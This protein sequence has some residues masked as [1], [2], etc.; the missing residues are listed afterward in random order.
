MDK[1]Y[2]VLY[3]PFSEIVLPK[4]SEKELKE[5]KKLKKLGIKS[6]YELLTYF[7]RGY[8][9]RTNIKAI[10]ELSENE[11]V[12]L[13]ATVLKIDS[14]ATFSNKKIVKARVADKTGVLEL[15]WF[16]APYVAKSL[17]LGSEYYFIGTAKRGYGW[18]MT[19]PEY[20]LLTSQKFMSEGE[21]LPIYSTTKDID[22]NVLRKFIKKFYIEYSDFFMENIPEELIRK[23]KIMDRKKTLYNIHF[24]KNERVL[25]EAKRRLAIEELLILEMGILS[26]RYSTD[27]KNH[28]LYQMEDKKDFVKIFLEG[29]K[30]ELTKA[31]K[32]V[33]TEVYKELSSGKIVNRLIQGDVGSG[34][35]I[36][37]MVLL[38]YMVENGYQGVIMAPTEILATQ[39][40]INNSQEFEKLGIKMELL[41]GSL[42]KKKKLEML[43]RIKSGK[44]DVV[45][46]THAVIQE[47][48]EFKK[49][50]LIVI[51]EQHRF[52]VEQRKAIRDKGVLANVIVMSA[53]PIPRSLALSIYGD[54]DVS[55][56]DELP[57]GR[58]AIKT[59]HISDHIDIEKMYGFI[60]KKLKET[61]QAYFIAPLIDESEKSNLKSVYELH[62]EVLKYLPD[63]RIG[64][65]HGKMKTQEKDEVMHRFKNHELDIIISTTVIEVG[66]NVTNASIMTI[67]DA[68]RFGLSSL[69]QLRGRVGRGE[70]QSYC[71][72]ISKSENET[73]VARMKIMEASNDGFYIAEEDLKL[74][75]PGEIFGTRQSGV[76]DLKFIDIVHDVKTIKLVR[77]EC[78]QYLKKNNGEIN[79][80]YL[81]IDIVQ[82]FKMSETE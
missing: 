52:G 16:S 7:P 73:S 75:K 46:A 74:R 80:I 71:F 9:N 4:L 6:V 25:E 72:L 8:D 49:L 57:P 61:R 78:H 26:S 11:Y 58:K 24:P 43:E 2:S 1:N 47:N 65:L 50:G 39:H 31:Q 40:F 62:E 14:Q 79:N 10:S 64:I 66:V 34:K 5:M 21:I 23:Y 51:D 45:V 55:I 29:L 67:S 44:T 32:K 33:I 82:K 22:Q 20:K 54:L 27:I 70:H 3:L 59:K 68:E 56:I 48:V 38:L 17:K 30:F 60:D 13:K 63:Y 35:T 76:T 81:K 28:S 18:Q 77:D 42:T 69:H 19:N 36:V 12:V 15:T 53:T 41:T 37:S